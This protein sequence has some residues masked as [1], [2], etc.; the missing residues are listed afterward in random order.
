MLTFKHRTALITGAGRGIGKA[1]AE[2]LAKQGLQP[3]GGT[4]AELADLTSSD[5][6]RWA[7]V[8][9]DANIRAD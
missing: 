2:T 6:D 1:I 4:P 3:T 8:I 9:R 7:R 5:L